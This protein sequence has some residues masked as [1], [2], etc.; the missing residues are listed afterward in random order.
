MKKMESRR[1]R[2]RLKKQKTP[3]K[4][5]QNSKE[6]EAE[7]WRRRERGERVVFLKKNTQG[8]KGL[9]PIIAGCTSK[10]TGCT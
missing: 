10:T 6:E 5:N 4:K 2:R 8:L 3:R 9:F 1:R 7:S